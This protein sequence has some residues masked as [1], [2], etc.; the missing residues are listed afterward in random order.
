MPDCKEVYFN[1]L[2]TEKGASQSTCSSYK[3][4][5][6][7]F[8]AYLGAKSK[9]LENAEKEDVADYVAMLKKTGKSASTVMRRMAS[10]RSFY[11]LMLQ[12][13]VVS[14]NPAKSVKNYTGETKIPEILTESETEILLSMPDV[15]TVL[16]MRD[17]ALI[18]I[19]YA[20]GMRVSE[21]IGLDIEN[22]NTEI[23]FI[24]CKGKEKTRVIPI[25]S[26][27]AASLKIYI[28]KARPKLTDIK[29]GPLFLNR[30]GTRLSRQGFWKL[31]KTYKESAKITKEITPH[32]LRHSFAVHLL[33]NGADLKSIQEMLGH[34]H[35]SSMRMY[36]RIMKQRIKNVYYNTHPKAVEERKKSKGEELLG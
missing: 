1:Y 26:E 29:T 34:S 4:D 15:T 13:G 10:I 24:T 23:G 35:M 11:E 8:E 28:S 17:K 18:E 20:T 30:N 36:N 19:L 6:S 27:A 31:I 33:E 3:N 32:T 9:K 16:G 12:K 5:I 21:L 7:S 2:K 14:E 22:V 25:Y